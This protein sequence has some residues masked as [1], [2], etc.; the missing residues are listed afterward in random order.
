L[1]GWLE[2]GR[3]SVTG[4]GFKA[5]LYH[6]DLGNE[7]VEGTLFVDHYRLRFR[8][9]S[10]SEE[11]PAERLAV[12]HDEDGERIR[13]EDS[14]RPGL[15][16]VT[17]DAAVLEHC[18]LPQL[19]RARAELSELAGRRELWRRLR[20]TGYF[21]AGC[22]LVVWLFTWVTGAMVRSLANAV[23]PEW[24]QSYGASCL[25]ELQG[26][27][28]PDTYS[29]QVA[30]LAALAVPL[31]GPV[32]LGNT[33][34]KFYIVEDPMPNA[35]ALPGGYVVVNTGLLDMSERPEELLGV[36]AHELAHVTQKHHARKIIDA[37]GP[38]LVFGLFLH[39]RSGLLNVLTEGSGLMM[40]QGFSKELETEA[41]ET[42]WR[43]LVA[44]NIDPRGMVSM[45]RKL[46]ESEGQKGRRQV[47]EAFASH[48][49]LQ[50]RIAR[51][52][53]KW[54]KLPHKD[55]FLAL[56]NPVPTV[57]APRAGGTTRAP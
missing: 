7:V 13:F 4:Q 27:G 38:L 6:P 22:V 21:L 56:T 41:D 36:L 10:L 12:T 53:S 55:G 51:L 46:E 34:A 5:S 37:S 30:A 24:E 18:A 16:I 48:P 14:A 52:E 57:R 39:S 42:G 23:P 26:E 44:A 15:E 28:R 3:V 2:W 31:L 35:F 25:K 33:T 50:K 19:E 43:Y 20:L 45:F 11:I 1:T 17:F 54:K 47:P 40:I 29:N 9:E 8:S 49:A 32:P